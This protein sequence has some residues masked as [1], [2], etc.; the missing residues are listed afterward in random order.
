M[1]KVKVSSKGQIAIPAELRKQYDIKKGDQLIIKE[2]EEGFMLCTMADQELL[3]LR[4]R[5]KDKKA[6][7]L[8]EALL[9]ERK[10]ERLQDK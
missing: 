10:N 1:H 2:S 3:K 4:G 6:Q 7:P 5:F 9:E 8:V